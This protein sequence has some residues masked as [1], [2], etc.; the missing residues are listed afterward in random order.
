MSAGALLRFAH[1]EDAEAIRDI[2]APHITDSTVSF[3]LE[4]PSVVE[5][6]GRMGAHGDLMPWIVCEQDGV[7]A[8]YAYAGPHRQRWAYQ[9]AV[10][11]SVYIHAAYRRQRIGRGLYTALFALLE[12][13]GFARAYAGVA[14][15]NEASVGLHRSLGFEPVGTYE[16]VGFKFGAWHDV[17]WWQRDLRD[18]GAKEPPEPSP[19]TT[20]E[21]HPVEA[22][23]ARGLAEMR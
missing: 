2:Y 9:W 1:P 22:A 8:G 18:V 7:V 4:V 17:S 23:F 15:P 11:V 3:E 16:R 14:L 12:A 13:Q 20:L 5:M 21:D 10:E 6:V 19:F